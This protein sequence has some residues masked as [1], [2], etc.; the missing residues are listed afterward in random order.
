MSDITQE[1]IIDTDSRGRA[2]IGHPDQRYLLREQ[3][4]GAIVLEPAVVMSE[5]ERRFLANTEIQEQIAHARA[6]P[7]ERVRWQP[8]R[9]SE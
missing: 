1:R 3:S 4:D 5:L 6:H 7:E 2:T 9:R 8:R